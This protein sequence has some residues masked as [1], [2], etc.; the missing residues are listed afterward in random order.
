MGACFQRCDLP[1]KVVVALPYPFLIAVEVN[2]VGIHA[3]RHATLASLA[4][5]GIEAIA[6]S[7][8]S[9]SHESFHY[10]IRHPVHHGL[11]VNSLVREAI[12]AVQWDVEEIFLHIDLGQVELHVGASHGVVGVRLCRK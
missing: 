12:G 8:V 1:S 7:S 5:H 6:A 4:D 11:V 3:N 10:L 2:V 9:V